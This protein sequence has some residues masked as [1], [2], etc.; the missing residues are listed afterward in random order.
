MEVGDLL[1]LDGLRWLVVSFDNSTKLSLSVTIQGTRR[2][3]PD[4]QEGMVIVANPSKA[5]NL[6]IAPIKAGA[7]PFAKLVIPGFMGRPER[8]LTP[9]VDWIQ[10]DPTR[11]GGSIFV[12]PSISLR[13]GDV[14]VAT[15]RS[16]SLL[17]IQI[18]RTFGTIAQRK[19][20]LA[21]PPPEP[22]NRFTHI[23]DDDE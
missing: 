13:N 7:G 11:E 10:G 18:P 19:A 14:L 3:I 6:L 22:V 15:H 9:W 23:L 21:K 5:W 2:E 20:R 4:D 12:H 16:G 1:E 17:R 8:V